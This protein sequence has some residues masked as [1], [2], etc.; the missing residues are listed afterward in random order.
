MQTQEV[1]TMIGVL[2]S[3]YERVN[4][5]T[6][7]LRCISAPIWPWLNSAYLLRTSG[8]LTNSIVSVPASLAGMYIVGYATASVTFGHLVHSYPPFKLMSVGLAIWLLAVFMSG[9]APHFWV[10]V[11]ARMLS[12]VGEAS[13]QTVV[14]P[15]IDD[16]SPPSKRGLWLSIFFM[17]IPVGTAFG[18]AWGGNIATTMSWRW[19]FYIEGIPMLPLIFLIWYMPYT[20]SKREALA[21]LGSTAASTANAVDDS[22][23]EKEE[24]LLGAD[25]LAPID[26]TSDHHATRLASLPEADSD[27]SLE[28]A[29]LRQQQQQQ[30]VD[31]L[32]SPGATATPAVL[33][34]G[35]GVDDAALRDTVSGAS[36]PTFLQELAHVLTEPL[37]VSV[38][39]GYAGYTAVFVSTLRSFRS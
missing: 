8:T 7:H 30:L 5:F 23:S 25:G 11:V 17:A 29:P 31:G 19:A 24:L 18:Y 28:N 1:R 12:G 34:D 36:K 2:Q 13:F 27:N 26:V 6:K 9:A 10:L 16:N 35:V 21:K 3:E 33:E 39:L 22:T 15:F 14:P 4:D 20:K 38:I 32:V 37:F